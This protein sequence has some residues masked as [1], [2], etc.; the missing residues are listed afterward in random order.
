[1]RPLLLLVDL[2]NDFLSAPGLEPAAPEVVRGA[3]R[4]LSGAR[5]LRVPVIHAVTSVDPAQDARMP[6]W[7]ARGRW[8]CLRGTPGHA[9]PP[10]LSPLDSEAVVSKTFFSAFSEPALDAALADAAA[11]TLLVA[12]V[13]LHG[14]VRATVLD[15]YQRGLSVWVA[16]DAV[17]SD[18][19]LH[20]AVT[21]RYL[22]SRAAW[23]APSSELLRRLEGKP[24]RVNASALP[25]ALVAGRALFAPASPSEVHRSPR[26]TR[27]ALFAVTASG[28]AEVDAAVCAA[29]GAQPGW[30]SLAVGDRSAALGRLADQLEAGAPTLARDLAVDVGKPVTDGLAEIVR[31]VELLRS[32]SGRAWEISRVR[33]GPES[34]WRRVALGV[35]AAVTPWNNPVAIPIGKIAPALA[36][37]NAVVWKP[38]P[39][40]TRIALTVLELARR[41]GLPDGLIN[42]VAGG[43]AA[44]EALMSSEGVDGVSLSGSSAAG[45]TAQEICARRRVALQAELGGNNAAIVWEGADLPRAADLVTRG[46]FSFAGQRCTA[47]RRVIVDAR[48]LDPI[49][50]ALAA[51]TRR[52]HWGDPLEPST[53]VGP[54]ISPEARARVAA[55]IERAAAGG[56]RILTPHA[57]A[58]LREGG[59][60][61]PPTLIVSRRPASPIVQ[62]ESFGPVLVVQP[63]RDFDHAL[64]LLNGVRQGLVAALFAGSERLREQFFRQ[65]LAG[66]LKWNQA[67]SGTDSAAPFGGWKASGVGP[68]ERGPGDAQFY[69]RIQSLYGKA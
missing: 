42:L 12:G 47:N 17:G 67:T 32:A 15:A 39:P 2:Q 37:G 43:R 24:A 54:L 13:H 68:P 28:P 1:M 55:S 60:Y 69:T 11:D 21:R 3:A 57:A 27:E 4:L 10:E 31:A 62:E 41:A 51:A 66:V 8:I 38:S 34:S 50:D 29:R 26:D 23:F 56:D 45:W 33:C 49:V 22:E 36:W 19:P 65:A 44:A 25:A 40:A 9:S 35:V 6:H 61:L 16:E 20:A 63:A 18:D 64:E 7:K 5:A 58:G 59:S 14:C 52:L 48:S 46:A 53:D 30:E